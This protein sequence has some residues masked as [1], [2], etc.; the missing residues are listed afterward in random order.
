[1]LCIMRIEMTIRL[2]NADTFRM[3]NPCTDLDVSFVSSVEWIS[4]LA[5]SHWSWS[6]L[7]PPSAF[8]T[9]ILASSGPK[10]L[11]ACSSASISLNAFLYTS[12]RPYSWARLACQLDFWWAS[13]RLTRENCPN[14]SR[15]PVHPRPHP[16]GRNN[17]HVHKR[18]YVSFLR[19]W[20]NNIHFQ[21]SFLLRASHSS[22]DYSVS[23]VSFS[24]W[25]WDSQ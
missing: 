8:N 23:H 4:L 10:S 1:M 14:R 3:R 6:M 12:W 18:L 21:M 16:E 11:E 20:L 17:T 13:G 22:D 19:I 5:A 2:T 25:W 9:P 24:S 7:L 15:I